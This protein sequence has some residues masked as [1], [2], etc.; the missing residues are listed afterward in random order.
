MTA[1][2]LL[3]KAWQTG[4]TIR[5]NGRGGL[6]LAPSRLLTPERIQAVRENKTK[7]LALVTGLE[8]CGAQSDPLI[9]E[10][11]AVF[12][13]T[14]SRVALESA[15]TPQAEPEREKQAPTLAIA[16]QAAFQWKAGTS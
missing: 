5:L 14:P 1:Q 2:E 16:H 6:R 9:L 15:R 10:A 12:N 13:A 3:F 4:V 11:L 8:Q 7:L